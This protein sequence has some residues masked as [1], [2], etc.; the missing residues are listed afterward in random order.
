MICLFG[1]LQAPDTYAE[2]VFDSESVHRHTCCQH[3]MNYEPISPY[4]S[5]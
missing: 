4:L 1:F 2:I 5:D 3:I